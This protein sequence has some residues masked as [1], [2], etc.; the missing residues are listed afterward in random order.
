MKTINKALIALFALSV[1][2]A[3]HGGDSYL[4]SCSNNT[5]GKFELLIAND[6]VSVITDVKGGRGIKVD[7]RAK[8][9]DDIVIVHSRPFNFASTTE[10]LRKKGSNITVVTSSVIDFQVFSCE[11]I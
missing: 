4:L 1:S 2:C 11:V 3:S 10:T 7:S 6:A 8:I 5:Q 9:L